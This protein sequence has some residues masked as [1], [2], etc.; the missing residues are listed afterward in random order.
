ME[1]NKRKK[2]NYF[3]YSSLAKKSQIDDSD[4]CNIA[5]YEKNKNDLLKFFGSKKFE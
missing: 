1:T 2:K 3:V 5:S 4:R